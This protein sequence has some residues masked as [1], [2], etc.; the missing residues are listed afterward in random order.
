MMMIN[1][2]GCD[3][4]SNFCR[5]QLLEHFLKRL[6]QCVVNTFICVVVGVKFDLFSV[7]K[8]F[9]KKLKEEACIS[10]RV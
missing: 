8:L 9:F 7:N 4:L 1:D 3:E 5:M 2:Y 10:L 6:S